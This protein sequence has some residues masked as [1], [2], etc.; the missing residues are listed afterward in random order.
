MAGRVEEKVF[1][2][3]N[4]NESFIVEAGAGSG[5]TW[6]LVHTLRYI[7]NKYGTCYNKYNQK[8]A[9]ITYTNVGKNEIVNRIQD[10]PLVCVKTI[11][12]F[13]WDIVAPFDKELKE[14]LIDYI[15][16]KLNND[17]IEI[18]K[19]TRTD[20]KV[21]RDLTA[22]ILRYSEILE[23]LTKYNGQIYYKEY[24]NWRKGVIT[25]DDVLYIATKIISKYQVI[26]KLIQD[27]YP[28]I[29]ID[30]YQDTDKN[31]ALSILENLMPNTS[32]IF[33]FFGDYLQQIY[34]GSI[35]KIDAE[36]YGLKVVTKT[37]NFRCSKEVIEI[38]N[39]L[40]DD[41]QQE[42]AGKPKRGRCFFYYV[43]DENIDAESFVDSI[44][45]KDFSLNEQDTLKK[46]YLTTRS[47]A[48][49]NGYSEL[50][51]LYDERE[52]EDKDKRRRKHKEQ[53]L[54]NK[55]NRDCPF[56]NFLYDIE[57]IVELYNQ[58]KIQMLLKKIPFE[59]SCF[60]DKEELKKNLDELNIRIEDQK[61]K[62]IFDFVIEKRIQNTPDR[63]KAY[64]K[65]LDLQDVFYNTLMSLEYK[66]FR[67]LYYTVKDTSPFSTD[68]GTKGAEFDNVVCIINDRDWTQSYS[69]N[70]YLDGT[71]I[72]NT[73]YDKTKNLFYVIC[74]RARYNLAIVFL[75]ELTSTA[76]LR[77][78]ELFGK[79]FIPY[80]R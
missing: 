29:L 53:I 21:Y 36:K 46:L 25:H 30:E 7:I 72:G 80:N 67:N 37:E 76:I 9:C 5:K 78:K 2:C 75:S 65:N 13:L 22:S 52:S 16:E 62:D 23:E 61:I 49:K 59:I 50:H 38:L 3:I 56:A 14:E 43:N 68:H 41:I 42:Q 18:S 69:F 39:K 71:D 54:K 48:I 26:K 31:V 34:G 70:K 20:T 1:E 27:S 11:H 64:L 19:K 47:V 40:R 12:D 33:G 73:R 24:R 8:I 32:I 45:K 60:A 35:G 77:A 55:D 10:N 15:N 79:N 17:R 57:E 28:I 4:K 66:Q 74:S 44:V 51:D 58:N 63:L 6:T